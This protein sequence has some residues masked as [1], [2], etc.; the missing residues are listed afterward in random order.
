ME[1][2]GNEEHAWVWVFLKESW[3]ISQWKALLINGG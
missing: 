2:R 1:G 3:D